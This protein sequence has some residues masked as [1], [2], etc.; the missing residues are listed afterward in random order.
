MCSSDLWSPDSQW[1]AFTQPE[2]RRFPNIYLYSL[3]QKSKVQVTDGWFDVGSPEFSSDGKYLFFVS[4][5]SFNPTY[6]QTEWNHTY[7]DME[8]I[9][10]VTLAA[11][12]KSP[13][14]PKSDEV[15]PREDKGQTVPETEASKGGKESKETPPSKESKAS[16]VVV[17]V[18]A[19]GLSQRITALPPAASNYGA[20]TSVENKLYYL[21]KGKLHLFDLEKEKETELGEVAGFRISADRKKMLVKAGA[22]LAIL[23]LPTAKLDLTDRKLNLSDLKV[24]LDRAAE[25][26]QIH[27]ECWRQMRDFLFDPKLHGVD[28]AAMR[29]RYQP[30]LQHVRHRADLTYLI[31]EMIE[32]GRAHV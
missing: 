22:D 2:V 23:D 32:I 15:K 7:S 21:K 30:L 24:R 19:E 8:R 14:A 18:D 13:L 6:G 25:W 3:A 10:L 31:G 4:E 28:W 20:L 27:A 1:L 16:K 29:Q 26:Q 12:T 17:T 9:Y 11:A 5:R